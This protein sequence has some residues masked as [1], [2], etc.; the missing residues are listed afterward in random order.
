LQIKR[1]NFTCKYCGKNTTEDKV[2]LVVDHII[3]RSKGGSNI[4]TRLSKAY[5][6]F[7][8]KKG[9]E[10]KIASMLPKG[11]ATKAGVSRN[12]KDLSAS[13]FFFDAGLL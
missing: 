11:L 4:G 10:V 1:D 5:D 6:V 2:K 7:I 13:N 12:L 3:P 9:K 8:R